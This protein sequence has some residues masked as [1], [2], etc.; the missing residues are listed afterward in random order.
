M[1]SSFSSFDK[2]F[3][4][5][6]TTEFICFFSRRLSVITSV[7]IS[8]TSSSAI[9]VESSFGRIKDSDISVD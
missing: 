9:I 3:K 8:R 2:V 6:L 4:V 5:H 7:R 1:L